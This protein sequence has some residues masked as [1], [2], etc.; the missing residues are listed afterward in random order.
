[1]IGMSHVIFA[2]FGSGIR[3]VLDF[4]SGDEERGTKKKQGAVQS[5]SSSVNLDFS[6]LHL[7]FVFLL[8]LSLCRPTEHTC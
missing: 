3:R 6:L 2:M 5:S 1:M 8:L 7:L 4:L